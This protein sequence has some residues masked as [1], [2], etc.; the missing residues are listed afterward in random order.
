M[1]W[2]KGTGVFLPKPGKENYF[3]I[4][5][6]RLITF[7]SFQLKWLERLILYHLNDDT[8][9]QVRLSAAQYGF[10]AGISTE[11]AMHD[12]VRRVE[13][14]L[15]RKRTSLGIFLDIVGV[16]D[17]ITFRGIAVALRGLNVSSVLIIW[18]ENMMQYRTVQ[19]ELQG[20]TVK[21]EVVKGKP[22]GG[23][24][25]PF[26]WNCVLNNLLTELRYMG[27]LSSGLC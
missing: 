23:I 24:S 10:R 27:F 13:H 9:L 21:W 25:S 22:Q 14:C 20:E 3:E 1:A 15:A 5:F 16:F 6:F 4:K 2:K 19:V 17:N 7:T 8:T 11:T 18:I 12:F 26:L